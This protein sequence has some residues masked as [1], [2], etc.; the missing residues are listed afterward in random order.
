MATVSDIVG[1]SLRILRVIN[2]TQPIKPA[3]MST[4]IDALNAMVRRW[5][6][7]TLSLGWSDVSNPS[8][9][10]PVPDEALEAIAYNLAMRLRPEY[11]ASLEPD[12]IDMARMGLAALRRDQQL[13]T[14]IERDTRGGYYEIRTDS[15]R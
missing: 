5:E 8:D 10:L 3:D 13:S 7:N 9:A 12:V 1:R 4:A 15:Y 14:P 11:G 2:P 6:A